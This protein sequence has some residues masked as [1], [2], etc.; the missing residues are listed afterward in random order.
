MN[1]I[2]LYE[3]PIIFN[4]LKNEGVVYGEIVINCLYNI[5][6]NTHAS[7]II[8]AIVPKMYRNIMERD[9]CEWITKFTDLNI[10]SYSGKKKIRYECLVKEETWI[11]DIVYS[12]PNCSEKEANKNPTL[13][14]ILFE[15][16]LLSLS[17]EGLSFIYLPEYKI[18]PIPIL[19]LLNDVIDKKFYILD[20]VEPTKYSL[21]RI[22]FLKKLGWVDK[23]NI[24]K[25][26]ETVETND[27]CSICLD[28]LN[29][30]RVVELPCNHQYHL[31][32]WKEHLKKE[33]ENSESE[34]QCPLCRKEYK[35]WQ[36][37]INTI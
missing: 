14:G 36:V 11:L 35:L 20:N 34:I 17:R 23:K 12:T 7:N 32:C 2:S 33:I 29:T 8:Q 5:V 30:D 4:I 22:N 19:K 15:Y 25:F 24:L 18:V 26:K 9:L 3:N 16:D 13:Y 10:R 21:E 1:L 28:M 37:Y 27:K 31:L 6:L